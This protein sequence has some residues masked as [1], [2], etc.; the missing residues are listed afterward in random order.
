MK[1]TFLAL[2]AIFITCFLAAQ[3]IGI[4]TL[5]PSEKL[6]IGD[7]H[8]KVGTAVLAS[9]QSNLMKFGDGDFVTVG[10]SGADD[11]LTFTG[12]YYIF[13]NN[14]GFGG[15]VGINVAS[16]TV[17]AAQLQVN[18]TLMVADGSQGAG[19]IF[20]SDVNGLGAWQGPAGFTAYATGSQLLTSASVAQV[21]FL[22]VEYNTSGGYNNATNTF[23]AAVGGLYHF[24][25]AVLVQNAAAGQTLRLR[26]RKNGVAAREI[27]AVIPDPATVQ[28][29]IING[30]FL[31]AAGDQVDVQVANASFSNLLIL[32]TTGGS[33]P[34]TWFNGHLVR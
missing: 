1:K 21:A 12:S 4:A 10:E 6:H 30:D 9:G 31:L 3:N 7:G 17:P 34:V 27:T 24:D 15:R 5:T 11:Q 20:V 28:N 13:R 32:T 19:K 14:A 16:G 25:A 29:V 2:T 26:L 8:V 33:T 22:N 23:T 18:G